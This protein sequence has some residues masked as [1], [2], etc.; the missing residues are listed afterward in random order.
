MR[1]NRRS[2][3][4]NGTN[5]NVS[6]NSS[7]RKKKQVKLLLSVNEL[8]HSKKKEEFTGYA[9]LSLKQCLL[10]VEC[11]FILSHTHKHCLMPRK[12]VNYESH[13]TDE[14]IKIHGSYI[15]RPSHTDDNQQL[16]DLN[17][18]S[19]L[20]GSSLT[21]TQCCLCPQKLKYLKEINPKGRDIRST[22]FI[23]K[24]GKQQQRG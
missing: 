11:C 20:T 8:L 10:C 9:W 21:I 3:Y 19:L 2:P 12:Q 15:T 1:S 6:Q 4:L 18:V 22:P 13:F 17:I 7:Q 24:R 23:L 14:D 16:G 5:T